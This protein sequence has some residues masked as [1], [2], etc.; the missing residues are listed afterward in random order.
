MTQCNDGSFCCEIDESCCSKHQGFWANGSAVSTSSSGSSSNQT[1]LP[2]DFHLIG[3]PTS[4]HFIVE[5]AWL[6]T[7]IIAAIGW[8]HTWIINMLL[9]KHKGLD[10][11]HVA[12]SRYA[13]RCHFPQFL[14]LVTDFCFGTG[15]VKRTTIIAF[16]ADPYTSDPKHV[17]GYL[18]GDPGISSHLHDLSNCKAGVFGYVMWFIQFLSAWY[19]VF[20]T[21]FVWS[22]DN[23][24]KHQSAWL[25]FPLLLGVLNINRNT[26]AIAVAGCFSPGKGRTKRISLIITTIFALVV[27]VVFISRAFLMA[28]HINTTAPSAPEKWTGILAWALPAIE[29]MLFFTGKSLQGSLTVPTCL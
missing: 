15:L 25:Q 26:Y 20:V 11:R 28:F 21:S 13:G 17:I 5:N 4:W 10:P 7:A 23:V 2:S 19:A 3:E 14:S 22:K 29:A 24:V 27:D 1:F 6:S 8:I 12:D 9:A 18:S 16:L